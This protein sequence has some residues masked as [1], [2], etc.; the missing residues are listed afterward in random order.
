M[1]NYPTPRA[2]PRSRAQRSSRGYVLVAEQSE[3]LASGVLTPRTPLLTR[4]SLGHGPAG[5][6]QSGLARSRSA[7][8]RQPTKGPAA[9]CRL[10]L[11]ATCPSIRT[12]TRPVSSASA[13]DACNECS[14]ACSSRARSIVPSTLSSAAAMACCSSMGGDGSRQ[15]PDAVAR[16]LKEC[17][18]GASLLQLAPPRADQIVQ[19]EAVR[20]AASYEVLEAL[21]GGDRGAVDRGDAYGRSGREQHG[22]GR[23]ES[24]ASRPRALRCD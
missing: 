3:E 8:S 10:A 15:R 2:L 11:Q 6:G 4:S 24:Q 9:R 1:R 22:S 5:H 13:A 20:L 23:D 19:P 14:R 12:R 21:V 17:A 16:Y 7:R 18:A